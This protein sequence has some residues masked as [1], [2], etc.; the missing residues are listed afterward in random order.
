V[1]ELSDTKRP[2]EVPIQPGVEESKAPPKTPAPTAT[3]NEKIEILKHHLSET[4]LGS[5]GTPRA[6]P[7]VE[8]AI[9]NVSESTIATAVFEAVFY[10]EEGNIVDQV[11][12]EEIT[13]EPETS[14][15]ILI[16]CPPH[17]YDLVKSYD[18]R[19]VRTTTADVEKV[20]LRRHETWTTETGEEEIKGI[21]KNISQVKTDA[22][23][24]ATFY[25]A[26]EE[27]IGTQVVVLRDIEPNTIRQYGLSFRPQ[28]GDVVSRY[29]LR[30][31][32]YSPYGRGVNALAGLRHTS[33]KPPEGSTPANH[34]SKW[35]PL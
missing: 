14:R 22:A 1:I 17:Q 21:V 32:S 5:D 24:I 13:L 11:K 19:V 8:L 34:K 27:N 6:R 9:R 4:D 23:V 20:Q 31:N 29:T 33:E 7:G 26:N 18:A 16:A 25:D 28:E 10:D 12:H 15:A 30:A 35:N 3:G 2:T